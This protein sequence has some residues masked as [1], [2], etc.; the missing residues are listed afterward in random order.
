[1]YYLKA[2]NVDCPDGYQPVPR[3]TTWIVNTGTYGAK[4]PIRFSFPISDKLSTKQELI[5]L[6]TERLCELFEVTSVCTNQLSRNPR[7]NFIIG[8]DD[9]GVTELMNSYKLLKGSFGKI[10]TLS[11]SSTH[12]WIFQIGLKTKLD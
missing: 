9:V 4:E 3:P 5:E 11:I 6:S 10:S 7:N 8:I 2:F 1:M 12:V